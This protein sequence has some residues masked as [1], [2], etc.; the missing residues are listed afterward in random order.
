M[1]IRTTEP[2]GAITETTID[3]TEDTHST[4][5]EKPVISPRPRFS[6]GGSYDPRAKNFRGDVGYRIG[7]SPISLTIGGGQDRS[8]TVGARVDW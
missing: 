6:V 2:G 1:F 8:I 5:Q 3:S 7:D 4:E